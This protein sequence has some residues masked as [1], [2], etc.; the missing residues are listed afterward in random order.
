M[1]VAFPTAVLAAVLS[2]VCGLG[3]SSRAQ[4][5]CP[6]EAPVQA[7]LD[8]LASERAALG[9]TA[10]ALSE[11]LCQVAGERAAQ[12]LA[13]G[14]ADPTVADLTR[15][16]QRLRRV[17]YRAFRWDELGLLAPE[18]GAALWEAWREQD[19]ATID[20]LRQ[21]DY[22]DLGFATTVDP[23]NPT[24]RVHVVVVALPERTETARRLSVYADLDWLRREL[25]AATNRA[26]A[27]AGLPELRAAARLDAAAQTHAE[28]MRRGDFY[29]HGDSSGSTPRRRA[30]SAG[31]RP[32]VVAENLAR[33][34][35]KPS[36]V[37][38]R[39]LDSEGHRA[40]LLSPLVEE[41]GFGRSID[42]TGESDQILWVQVLG[43][44]M[45]P[46]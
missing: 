32:R 19:P 31:Y 36:E 17:G 1:S 18:E 25:L 20:R 9:A 21:G 45:G 29:G 15:I 12:R 8:R 13:N 46:P 41:V 7:F 43:K 40:N 30:E 24:R 39:W 2:T 35:Y 26:R 4:A 27:A 33:G 16:S 23:A 34:F 14:F 11:P 42:P 22:S 38:D 3:V 5:A 10:L 28:A 44:E 37:I 6:S